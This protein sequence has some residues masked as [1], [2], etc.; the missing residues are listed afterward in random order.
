METEQPEPTPEPNAQPAPSAASAAETALAPATQLP[1]TPITAVPTAPAPPASTDRSTGLMIFGILQI[2]LGLLAALMVPLVTLGVFLSRAGPA[3][4]MRPGQYV[5]SIATYVFLAAVLLTLGFGSIQTR[6]WA[7]ALTL[8]VSWYGFITGTL[9][10]ILL[11]AVLPVM[12]RSF[13]SHAEKNAGAAAPFSAGVMA[14]FLTLMIVFMA[15]F[16]IFVPL[17]FVIFYSRRDVALTCQ[18]RDPV[19][20]WTDRTPLPVLGASVVLFFGSLYMLT[21]AVSLPMFPFFGR[22]LTGLAAAVCL[23][24]LA[25]VDIYLSVAIFRLQPAGWWL[26]IVTV[27]LRLLSLALTYAKA[28]LTRAYQKLG[29]SDQQLQIVNANPMFRGHIILWW[30]LLTL[31]IFFGYL[32]WL[33]RY[34]RQP[35]AAALPDPISNLS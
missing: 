17:A 11:T 32:L 20:R 34:F 35:S 18:Q 21:T 31:V 9:T 14:V 19:E 26:A 10:T 28:D 4:P 5:S 12:M 6:R 23:F 30:S 25:A 15:F 29:F 22:Y 8:I 16:L 13:L 3:G 2:I 24:V 7:H 27:P 33:K 1:A